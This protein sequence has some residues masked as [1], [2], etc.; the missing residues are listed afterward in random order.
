MEGVAVARQRA[1][2]EPRIGDHLSVL[3]GARWISERAQ[4]HMGVT[5]PTARAKLER[6]DVAEGLHLC[7]HVAYGERAEHSGEKPDLH[8]RS[9]V[10][11]VVRKRRCQAILPVR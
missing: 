6:L 3:T 11:A 8:P 5:G 4:V 7:D 2:R 1:D 10:V 9:L